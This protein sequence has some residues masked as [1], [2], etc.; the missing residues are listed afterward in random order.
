MKTHLPAGTVAAIL[1]AVSGSWCPSAPT[2][3]VETEPQEVATLRHGAAIAGVAFSSDSKLLASG[4]DDDRKVKLWE[5]SSRKHTASFDVPGTGPAR[6]Q[7][8]AIGRD[9]KTVASGSPLQLWE[10]GT[11]ENTPSLSDKGFGPLA[12]SPDGRFLAYNG[13]FD[14]RLY[15]L[16]KKESR[17]L[18]QA[19]CL[20]LKETSQRIRLLR[21]TPEGK[22]LFVTV[23]NYT[24]RTF[25]LWDAEAGKK[26]ASFGEDKSRMYG[27]AISADGKVLASLGQDNKVR[28]WDAATGKKTVT[29]DAHVAEAYLRG[30]EGDL[31]LALSA[32][33]KLLAI[34]DQPEYDRRHNGASARVYDVKTGNE[35]AQ[36][37]GHNDV[38]ACLVFSPDGKLLA[39][40]SYDGTIKIWS[41]PDGWTAKKND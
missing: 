41:I 10:V 6:M 18:C 32:D 21:F 27:V 31:P 40:G 34:A 12:Y 29:V 38:I 4:G 22:L 9:G 25:A 19:I 30:R 26:L 1:L 17:A 8:L 36:L 28:L 15:D 2:P 23:A 35:L 3:A 11:G 33:G 20:E 13:G 5:V 39:T 14:V 37:K 7:C 16:K 24:D